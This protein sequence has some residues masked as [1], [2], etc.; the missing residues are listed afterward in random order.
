MIQMDGKKG[1]THLNGTA[2]ELTWCGTK[3]TSD[4]NGHWYGYDC[5]GA[6]EADTE[7]NHTFHNGK[8]SDC[9]YERL[10]TVE[11]DTDGGTDVSSASVIWTDKVL[12]DSVNPLKAGFRL[13][14]WEYN[15]TKV[16]A[17]TTCGTLVGNNDVTNIRLTALWKNVYRAIISGGSGSNEYFEGDTVTIAAAAPES[18]KKFSKWI[19]DD[20]VVFKNSRAE[21]T[22]FSMPP[23]TVTVTAVYKDLLP[24]KVMVNGI[25]LVND[26]DDHIIECGSGTAVYNPDTRTL[27]LDHAEIT[28]HSGKDNDRAGICISGFG[29]DDFT[30]R[31]VGTNTISI[32]DPTV[33]ETALKANNIGIFK[34]CYSKL[35][36]I[37]GGTNDGRLDIVTF[38]N[39]EPVG[40]ANEGD[41]EIGDVKLSF[42]LMDGSANSGGKM[43][44]AYD[45]DST[46]PGSLSN[47]EWKPAYDIVLDGTTLTAEDG[48]NTGL[49]TYENGTVTIKNK[50]D[51]TIKTYY[52]SIY[53][54]KT[55]T[56]SDSK[57]TAASTQKDGMRGYCG[58]SIS[59]KSV[60]NA[61]GGNY[62]IY[63][64]GELVIDRSRVAAKTTGSDV[65]DAIRVEK[66]SYNAE[67]SRPEESTAGIVLGEN[68]ADAS[69]AAIRSG[70][71]TYGNY[72]DDTK[73]SLQSVW[74]ADS[75]F[76]A[77]DGNRVSSV[78]IVTVYAVEFDS[79]GGTDVGA[80]TDVKWNDKVLDNVE[81]PTYSKTGYKFQGWKYGKNIVDASTRYCDLAENESVMN[82]VLTAQWKDEEDPTGEISVG[83]EKWNEL[84][85]KF[86]FGLFFKDTQTI[87]ITASDNSNETVKIEYLK[88]REK[89]SQTDLESMT[90]EKEYEDPFTIEPD[91]DYIVYVRLTDSS[92]NVSYI[93][94]DEFVL[95]ATDP[96]IE[97]IEDGETYCGA[98]TVTVKETNVKSVTVKETDV[99][100][101][102]VSG[103]PVTLDKDGKF[104]LNPAEGKQT[105]T[106]T[107]KA[108]NQTSMAVTVNDG[109]TYRWTSENGQYWQVCQICQKETAKKNIPVIE[110]HGSDKVCKTQDYTC[111]FTL[112]EGV[113]NPSVAA[114]Q[115][116][117]S[118]QLTLEEK[119]G[120]CTVTVEHSQYAAVQ[121][122]LT[123]TLTAETEDGYEFSKE[124]TA[125]AQSE[126]TFEDGV[127]N[128]CLYQRRYTIKYDANGGE[129]VGDRTDVKWN[130]KVLDGVT[131][132]VYSKSGYE[133]T[134]WKCG[135][136]QIE[137]TTRYCDLAAGQDVMNL[138]LTAQWQDI[139]E[140]TGKIVIGKDS[141]SEFSDT[142]AFDHYFREAG[143][144][145]IT[146]LDNSGEDVRTEY[147][148]SDETVEK[149]ALAEKTFT[150]YTGAFRLS[151]EQ[152][153]IIYVRLTDSSN[154]VKYI[155]SDGV[156]I[157]K[158]AP[159]LEGIENG[160]TYCSSKTI[161]VSEKYPDEVKV[162][163]SLITLDEDGTFT[164]LPGTEKQTVE[165]VDK[166]GNTTKITVM[167]RDEHD[168]QWK[169]AD[170]Q[171]WKEC[172]GCKTE[173]S[174]Q[175]C[176]YTVEFDSNGGSDIEARTDVKWSDLVLANVTEPVYSKTGYE[177]T[178]WTH[179][180][181]AVEKTVSYSALAESYDVKKITLTAQW[182]DV[183]APG[184]EI[185]IDEDGWKQ[186][187]NT[188]TFNLFFKDTK[189]VT[190]T[191]SDN[192][193]ENVEIAYLI[194]SE[195]L[196][197]AD[198]DKKTFTR[199]KE[200]FDIT[201]DNRY[202]VYARL[203]DNS[204]NVRYICSN[205]VVLDATV[206]GI[207]GIEDGASYCGNQ[208]VTIKDTYVDE[209]TVN[210]RAVT[211]DDEGKIVLTPSE[212][213]QTVVVKDKAGNAAQM[214]VLILGQHRGGTAFCDKQAECAVCHEKYGQTDK[215][216]HEHLKHNEAKSATTASE[217]NIEHW[218]CQAC[219]KYFADKE[220]SIEISFE[221][222]V[223]AKLMTPIEEENDIT[224]GA[225]TPS[226]VDQDVDEPET[227]NRTDDTEVNDKAEGNQS[228]VV[229]N[230]VKEDVKDNADKDNADKEVVKQPDLP[231]TG[232]SSRMGLWFAL[233]VI[234]GALMGASVYGRRKKK[235]G[236]HS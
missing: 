47:P 135:D 60:I 195:I 70:D 91:A 87:T 217:G 20:G 228:A 61:T 43:I 150:E 190:I 131:A 223:V 39:H 180:D 130:D 183:E 200:P 172:R 8:C 230:D 126:H 229:K 141:W 100:S 171:C 112:P 117:N 156:V 129:V 125:A 90:F 78:N 161:T 1:H 63:T 2:L 216:C 27:T 227:D 213:E 204:G 124:K 157:D 197:E 103:T 148:L 232:D 37:D 114:K 162:N 55:I 144:V 79:N 175:P 36:I 12:G 179:G 234:N 121:E 177:F 54:E 151:T 123:I 98:K 11:Y 56:V 80:K 122:T 66:R 212:N 166:A 111:S 83:T 9:D 110:I 26:D 174:K 101:A 235:T 178:G 73:G 168:W 50:A 118:V 231:G 82:I 189:K 186:F 143:E 97:G 88:S 106:V 176:L 209:V 49:F 44:A 214:T 28:T 45:Y 4:E 22:T 6:K 52:T 93:C 34:R 96:V 155:C 84:L 35:S 95:D 132:P 107:D 134:G 188:I 160:M 196:Q 51:V 46:D 198:L 136:T 159:V 182:K 10:Y 205:G 142:I 138:T 69:G 41:I 104:T 53:S 48:Y 30:I 40:I 105:V 75:Y 184:G 68:L 154:N 146:A 14:G 222:T 33:Y 145:T 25:D 29:T 85:N 64:N 119:N 181:T 17:D 147:F 71:W 225:V 210:G 77:K 13:I 224:T 220:G 24:G 167:I 31:L 164:L 99:S 192:S 208:V 191:A 233:L 215:N 194:S 187:L 206:P 193:G 169:S 23:K 21:T 57:V 158:T 92:K 76:V 59:D 221:D 102:S 32:A 62:G 163:G 199:Y 67:N 203:T 201:S 16:Y 108:G 170:G 165:V 58:I 152:K 72:W 202:I 211:P 5:C 133:F 218:Y 153:Y 115:N 116:G 185:R 236:S 140:P 120:T 128:V 15:K 226:A 219:N 38:N 173:T 149:T 18:G 3:Y 109:H 89:Y 65:Q 7:S 86:K 19:A 127:C 207:D 137:E 94:S 139:S 42:A 113:K 74:N 81:E